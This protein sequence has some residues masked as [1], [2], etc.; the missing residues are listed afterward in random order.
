MAGIQ[1]HDFID[2]AFM[3]SN[4]GLITERRIMQSHKHDTLSV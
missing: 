1:L 4:R 3:N 2:Y